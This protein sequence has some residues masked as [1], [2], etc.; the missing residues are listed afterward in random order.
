[1]ASPHVCGLAA[2]LMALEGIDQVDDVVARITQLAGTTG[3]SVG[4]NRGDTTNLI[5]YNGAQELL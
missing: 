5:A 2:Y 1:M 4:G 3:A